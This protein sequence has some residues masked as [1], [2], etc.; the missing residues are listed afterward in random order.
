MTTTTTTHLREVL[1][2]HAQ[3]PTLSSLL[4]SAHPERQWRRL[5]LP[6]DERGAVEL[7]LIGWPAGTGTGWH[8]HGSASGAFTVL[9]GALTEYTWA[10][11][12][13]VRHLLAGTGREFAGN[14][15]HDVVN[16]S[17]RAALSLHAYRPRLQAM[18]KYELVRGHLRVAGVE[19]A[20]GQW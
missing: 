7:W 14:H 12:S 16:E 19:R 13:H 18:T 5:D 3:D 15:I 6:G 4:D 1:H 9:N 8:D 17:G 2:Q 20:G 11:A 10:G